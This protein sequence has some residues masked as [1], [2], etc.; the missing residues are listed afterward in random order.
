MLVDRGKCPFTDKMTA[1]AMGG[2][3]AVVVADNV[4]EK[5]MGGT[6]GATTDVKIPVVSVAKADGATLRGRT[7]P[8]TLKLNASV[9]DVT[10]R[11]VIAQTKTGSTADVV[12]AGAHLDS[13]PEGPGINDNGSGVAG[14]L[15]TALQ[16]GPTP[17]VHNAVR[18]GFWGAEELGLVGSERYIESLDLDQLRDIAL[19]LNFDMIASPNAGYFTY[20]GDQSAPLDRGQARAAGAGGLGRDRAHAGRLPQGRRKDRTGHV[21]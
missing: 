2:A 3:V 17:D 9:R 19:Y 13:V 21:F 15:E 6:L 10:A 14:V 16:L 20:D 11:N 1:A 5:E 18:F 7:G 4:D 8:V 12:M